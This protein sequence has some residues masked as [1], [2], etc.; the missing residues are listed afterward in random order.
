M[1]SDPHESAAPDSTANEDRNKPRIKIGSQRA[2]APPPRVPPRV[3]TVFSTPDPT[4]PSPAAPTG[5]AN[6]AAA[7]SQ[8]AAAESTAAHSS[9]AAPATA[10]ITA[11]TDSRPVHEAPGDYQ[12]QL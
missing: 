6:V 1:T 8:S 3:K 9:H 7:P 2:G 5:G 10:E 12:F 11:S 4:A